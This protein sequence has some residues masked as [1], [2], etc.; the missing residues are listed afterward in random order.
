MLLQF[1]AENMFY[2]AEETA[3][4]MAASKDDYHPEHILQNTTPRTLRSSALYGANEHGKS[5]LLESMAFA[6]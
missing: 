1:V 2:F 5:K 6:K 3:F 4:S